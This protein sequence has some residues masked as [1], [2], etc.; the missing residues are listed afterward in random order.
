M[1]QSQDQPRVI[2]SGGKATLSTETF[3]ERYSLS[4]RVEGQGEEGQVLNSC[5]KALGELLQILDLACSTH[6]SSR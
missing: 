1:F 6:C 4:A 2:R 3:P 5:G